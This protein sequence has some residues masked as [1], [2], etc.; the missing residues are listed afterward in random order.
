MKPSR[1]TELLAN[2]R[3]TFV[4][5]FSIVMFVTLGV[6]LFL[7]IR[8]AAVSLERAASIAYRDGAFHDV[9]VAFPYGLD[10]DV[11]RAIQ[12]LDGV[13]L[14][15]PCYLSYQTHEADGVGHAV[16]VHSLTED[17]DLCA[18]AE[19]SLPSQADQVA[20]S[21]GYAQ[22]HGIGVG[23]SLSLAH[24]ATDDA[25][26]D[27]MR[28]LTCGDFTVTGI[29][30]NPY[31]LA[32][33]NLMLGMTDTGTNVE[34]FAYV[35][36]DAFDAAAFD[37]RH[38]RAL[39]RSSALASLDP[40]SEEYREQANELRDT[41]VALGEPRAQARF[42][43]IKA[44]AQAQVDEAQKLVD[45]GAA[46]LD[47]A[48][49]MIAEGEDALVSG[50]AQIDAAIARL[51]SGE[52]SY[53]TTKAQGEQ[54]LSTMRSGLSS[55]QAAH[56]EA[57]GSLASQQRNLDA[58]SSEVRAYQQAQEQFAEDMA[59]EQSELDDIDAQ[60]EEGAIT[61]EERQ[62]QRQEVI[63]RINNRIGEFESRMYDFPTIVEHYPILVNLPR[64]SYGD[65]SAMDENNSNAQMAAAG[66][67][68]LIEQA[69]RE[70]DA[71]AAH[72][73]DLG[74]QLDSG[75][76]Q[77][78]AAEA[79]L[80]NSLASA[81]GQ[82]ADGRDQVS[83]GQAE[84]DQRT[85][86][87][88][89]GKEL[90]EERASELEEGRARVAEAQD[91][92]DSMTY[93]S[94]IVS[95]R[96]TASGSIALTNIVNLTDNLR[97]AMAT[98][99]VVVGLLVCYSAIS[100]IVHEQVTQI[101]TK[102]AVGFRDGEVTSG[103]L[104]YTALATVLGL[105]LGVATSAFVV[106][107]I[108]YPKLA[109][110]F[111]MPRVGPSL[112]APDTALIGAVELVLLL[113]CTWLACRS[114][115]RRSA[116]ELLA[117]EQAG[118]GTTRFY[119]RWAAWRRLPLLTQTMINN[120]VSD[121]RRV[122]A[123]VIGVAGC[124]ALIVTAT[125]L[126]G[127]ITRSLERHFGTVYDFD[128][129][130]SFDPEDEGAV[131]R[132]RQAVEG[133]GGSCAEVR[134]AMFLLED[135]GEPAY[136][137]ILVPTDDDSFASL[138]HLNVVPSGGVAPTQGAWLSQSHADHRDLHVGDHITVCTVTGQRYRLTIAGFFTYYLPNN[139]IVMSPDYY[140]Q[141]FGSPA[142]PNALIAT[143]GTADMDGLTAAVSDVEGFRSIKDE[144]ASVANIVGLFK[145]VT[146]TVVAI[147]VALSAVMALI[148]L[149]NL[150][151]MFIDE[152]KRELI[153]LMINGFSVRDA[154]AYIYRDAIVMTAIGIVLGVWLGIVMGST[155]VGAVE[156]QSCSF[157]KDAYLPGCV[158]GA[159]MSAV[160][161]IA[162][163]LVALRR[164]PRF[165]LTDISRY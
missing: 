111:D 151:H 150:D 97:V 114:V 107:G 110:S 54:M 72:V 93:M 86:E 66:A 90:V 17:V 22:A 64:L 36:D 31:Y 49:D 76:S 109:G 132:V 39:V 106:Q 6:G 42:D 9:E 73:D 59:E 55:L 101:G 62:Q 32:Q 2:V 116:V 133:V 4:S 23:D 119:E 129:T 138:F 46:Q 14:V 71:I 149:L 81:E 19:G 60:Y 27:G 40:F 24:D 63:D 124:T 41:L 58:I 34:A 68:L 88:E 79:N 105:A 99:F 145:G 122:F 53:A 30:S 140:E 78:H 137:S 123:T 74:R 95:T 28:F 7:G 160:F 102:K 50:Q 120:C 52:A 96:S 148:V 156:W 103:Y 29:V 83:A 159:V 56:D 37:G 98:L 141:V 153:V 48:Q 163:M 67:E 5:F 162:M 155:T 142:T 85:D 135:E 20:I 77:Y 84:L 113:A 75:W 69:Q 115:L 26:P 131:E 12:G 43:A 38:P 51:A 147:Y 130:V 47:E 80:A 158:L 121:P 157:M 13:D 112:S 89:Q 44:A 128:A 92:V 143:T 8:G 70:L 104:A 21:A 15:V 3:S 164:I 65:T 161:A 165:S 125:T 33:S 152:K 136:E 117:G 57:K 61:E 91:L 108:L 25:D 10:D 127:N 144:R 16:V 134:S 35:T 100:R 154:K 146:S 94:W 139:M 82:I 11:L 18:V 45:E 87:L 126:D 1:I 118:N